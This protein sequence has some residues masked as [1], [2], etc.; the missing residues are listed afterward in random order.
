MGAKKKQTTRSFI[1]PTTAMLAAALLLGLLVGCENTPEPDVD[2]PASLHIWETEPLV[3]ED[4]LHILHGTGKASFAAELEKGEYAVCFNAPGGS[5]AGNWRSSLLHLTVRNGG[6]GPVFAYYT[7]SFD[8]FGPT[9][10][11]TVEDGPTMFELKAQGWMRWLIRVETL[12]RHNE[13][14]GCPPLTAAQ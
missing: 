2:V 14:G 4:G 7:P 3:D 11:L 8:L 10:I 5:I 12:D 9:Q 13:R 1:A 6:Q